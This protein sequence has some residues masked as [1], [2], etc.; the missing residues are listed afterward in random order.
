M[1]VVQWTTIRLMIV[2]EVLLGLKSEQ[3]DDTAIFVNA[4]LPKK[5]CLY[6]H[7][8]GFK[9]PGKV[10]KLNKALYGLHNF[11]QHFGSL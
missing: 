6:A 7:V 9:M 11:P 3:G 1:P 5:N 8:A 2:L 10:L 4:D